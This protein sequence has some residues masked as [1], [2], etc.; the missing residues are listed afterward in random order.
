M[1]LL[2]ARAMEVWEAA[3]VAGAALGTVGPQALELWALGIAWLERAACRLGP[4]GCRFGCTKTTEGP[5]QQMQIYFQEVVVALELQ[6]QQLLPH[7]VVLEALGAGER[8]SQA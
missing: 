4:Q 6:G 7:R 5:P 3:A 2:Q 8:R 1:L